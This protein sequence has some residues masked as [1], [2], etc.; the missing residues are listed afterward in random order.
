MLLRADLHRAFDKRRFT[1]LPKKQCT[2]VTHVFE[3][4]S[5]RAIYHNVALNTTY[6]APE[7]LFARFAWTILPL[8]KQFLRRRRNRLLLVQGKPQWANPDQCSDY[9]DP[10]NHK[11][12]SASPRKGSSRR[13][14]P[15]K[16]RSPSKRSR[17]EMET[18]GL[19]QDHKLDPRA[20]DQDSLSLPTKRQRQPNTILPYAIPA[21]AL[22]YPQHQPSA[23]LDGS[24]VPGPPE[25][26]SLTLAPSHSLPRFS[27]HPDGASASM[28][29]PQKTSSHSDLSDPF[30][31]LTYEDDEQQWMTCR[32]LR[33]MTTLQLLKERER[34][35]PRG[36]WEK[37]E[38]WL[39]GIL[40]SGG[41]LDSSEIKRWQYVNGEEVDYPLVGDDGR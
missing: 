36:H 41:A 14:S 15:T 37:E 16:S 25:A 10:P 1:F 17:E 33:A 29:T 27:A 24:R 22:P 2:L 40:S 38:A 39:D 20:G 3:S 32:D 6:N 34:S 5:L 21:P 18:D 8:V 35:D 30:R 23:L 11:S 26:R 19:A 13:C 28:T 4:E 7:Y 31:S 9:A 12:E